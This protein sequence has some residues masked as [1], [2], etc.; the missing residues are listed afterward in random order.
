[1]A[2]R[3][4]PMSGPAK[5]TTQAREERHTGK[6]GGYRT[7]EPKDATSGGSTEQARAAKAL[8]QEAARPGGGDPGSSSSGDPALKRR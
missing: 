5:T 1:M 7:V 4:T 6:S 3:N 8:Y 2:N